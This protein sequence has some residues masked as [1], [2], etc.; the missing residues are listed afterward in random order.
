MEGHIRFL[1]IAR[2]KETG[3][4]LSAELNGG[5]IPMTGVFAVTANG[6]HLDRSSGRADS[7]LWR[8]AWYYGWQE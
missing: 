3:D 8:V 5:D 2:D 1:L 4:K 6:Q 7:E